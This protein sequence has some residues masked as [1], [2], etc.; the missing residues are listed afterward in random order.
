MEMQLIIEMLA[1]MDANTKTMLAEMQK[2]ADA[3]QTRMEAMHKKMMARTDP[4]L[5]GTN[6]K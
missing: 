2:N 6:D 1:R 4:W 3:H 5:T